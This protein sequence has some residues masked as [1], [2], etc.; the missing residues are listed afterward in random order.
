MNYRPTLALNGRSV[1][2]SGTAA[3]DCVW[4][5]WGPWSDLCNETRTRDRTVAAPPMYGGANCTE[6]T[7]EMKIVNCA[8]YG[9]ATGKYVCMKHTVIKIEAWCGLAQY[10]TK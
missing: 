5:E 6:H 9:I 1:Y 10:P 7:S 8:D 4:A 2:H 3:M